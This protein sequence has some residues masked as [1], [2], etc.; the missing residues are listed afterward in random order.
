MQRW[1]VSTLPHMLYFPFTLI[2]DFFSSSTQTSLSYLC[3]WYFASLLFCP[4]RQMQTRGLEAHIGIN[5]H[6]LTLKGTCI[7]IPG[8]FNVLCCVGKFVFT[9]WAQTL[10]HCYFIHPSLCVSLLTPPTQSSVVSYSAHVLILLRHPRIL[11]TL[12]KF[13]LYSRSPNAHSHPW[14]WTQAHTHVFF[15]VFFS[16]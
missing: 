11:Q 13:W 4:R 12:A 7:L 6:P 16:D 15:F 5:T 9:Y 2:C 3:L 14:V 1:A 8:L 10:F